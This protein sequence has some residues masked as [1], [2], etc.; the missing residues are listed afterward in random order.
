[1]PNDQCTLTIAT[2]LPKS[3]HGILINK[4]PNNQKTV[5]KAL[6]Y[7]FSKRSILESS[8]KHKLA[9]SLSQLKTSFHKQRGLDA[10]L[11]AI[12]S[13]MNKRYTE[14]IT[15]ISSAHKHADLELT[16]MFKILPQPTFTMESSKLDDCSTLPA[17]K[18]LTPTKTGLNYIGTSTYKCLLWLA[19][20]LIKDQLAIA[21]ILISKFR[22]QKYEE[23]QIQHQLMP[24]Q[25]IASNKENI[26]SPIQ[27]KEM[28]LL[29]VLV[30]KLEKRQLADKNNEKTSAKF[31][32][33]GLNKIVKRVLKDA[34]RIIYNYEKTSKL[35]QGTI[36]RENNLKDDKV[37]R[38][39]MILG[40][41]FNS[42]LLQEKLDS[43]N[44]IGELEP[45]SLHNRN[46]KTEDSNKERQESIALKNKLLPQKLMLSTKA[47]LEFCLSKLLEFTEK[48]TF[49][50]GLDYL[51]P[52]KPNTNLRVL[53]NLHNHYLSLVKNEHDL[54]VINLNSGRYHKIDAILR[55]FLTSNLSISFQY[56]KRYSISR[57]SKLTMA[58]EHLLSSQKLKMKISFRRLSLIQKKGPKFL[59]TKTFHKPRKTTPSQN[60]AINPS[61]VAL[62]AKFFGTEKLV[63]IF[64]KKIGTAFQ[65]I[66]RHSCIESYRSFYSQWWK[67]KICNVKAKHLTEM[68]EQARELRDEKSMRLQSEERLTKWMSNRSQI[69][70]S[71]KEEVSHGFFFQ[72]RSTP[73][74]QIGEFAQES[75]LAFTQKKSSK[76]I[77]IIC[78]SDSRIKNRKSS[79][80]N[81]D[82]AGVNFKPTEKPTKSPQGNT[83]NQVR[84]GQILINLPQD[85]IQLT[86]LKGH[87]RKPS[88]LKEYHLKDLKDS[89]LIQH[90]S[91]RNLVD[92]FK[93]KLKIPRLGIPESSQSISQTYKDNNSIAI[94]PL[95]ETCRLQKLFKTTEESVP[96]QSYSDRYHSDAISAKKEFKIN[97]KSENSQP[98]FGKFMVQSAKNTTLETSRTLERYPLS[99][100]PKQTLLELW[101][102]RSFKKV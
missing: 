16:K 35:P 2:L 24:L 99:N 89:S 53:Q 23:N 6:R 56:I 8:Q 93:L 4:K 15:A 84:S 92:H 64:N 19:A 26:Y 88:T 40:S 83:I 9:E 70:D 45:R 54:T 69:P 29:K 43:L 86:V 3:Y 47:K 39:A 90:P 73:K 91:S 20:H 57:T 44:P 58:L 13:L 34:W 50:K 100:P 66:R 28:Q 75:K 78:S 25:P 55:D 80:I 41:L 96:T 85:S 21:F 18:S 74:F 72:R 38:L 46:D 37:D 31:L 97:L 65:V 82:K 76:G 17:T 67:W 60:I 52:S 81:I 59:F 10:I 32:F 61:R 101:K 27:S 79:R 11:D 87:S 12:R 14:G 49:K 98:S 30:E 102:E 68:N 7:K 33:I 51:D 63:K 1:M 94:R 77:S 71:K 36:F 62:L 48:P 42:T 95:I 22:N 5:K